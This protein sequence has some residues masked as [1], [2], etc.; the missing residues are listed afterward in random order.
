MLFDDDDYTIQSDFDEKV[1]EYYAELQHTQLVLDT[2]MNIAISKIKR[3][4]IFNLGLGLELSMK[5][6]G[7]ELKVN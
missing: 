5:N 1:N 6:C 4:A 2:S 7:I 3:N